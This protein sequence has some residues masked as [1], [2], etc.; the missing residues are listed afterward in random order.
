MNTDKQIEK[1]H[2]DLREIIDP[3]DC[4]WINRSTEVVIDDLIMGGVGIDE[5]KTRFEV[6][7]A[8]KRELGIRLDKA[9]HDRGRYARKIT[10]LTEENE[11]L[12][13]QVE[14]WKSTAYC[15]KD[16]VESVKIDIVRKMH[17]EI[18]ERCIKNGI[19]PAFVA[20][21]I[22]RIVEELL[23]GK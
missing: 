14:M 4:G 9:E 18:K 20:R 3:E 10:K 21:T 16:R 19:Y 8:I 11:R 12:E 7:R 23:E 22:D 13:A 6:E 5:F 15:E 2:D 17:S 1:L